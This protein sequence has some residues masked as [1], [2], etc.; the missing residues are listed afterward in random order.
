MLTKYRMEQASALLTNTDMPVAEVGRQ[1][2]ISDSGYFNKLFRE[3][4][5]MTP[6]RYRQ[7]H[8]TVEA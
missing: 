8:R 4:Y 1:V 6:K 2:G 5:G 7:Y 3:T